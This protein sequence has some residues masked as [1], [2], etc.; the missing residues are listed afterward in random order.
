M[1]ATLLDKLLITH[2]AQ[3]ATIHAIT[4]A[5]LPASHPMKGKAY[6]YI[7]TNGFVRVNYENHAR[8]MTGNPSFNAGLPVWGTHV[9]VDKPTALISHIVDGQTRYYIDFIERQRLEERYID[10]KGKPIDLDP[11]DII[12]GKPTPAAVRRFMLNNI[13]EVHIGGE[14]WKP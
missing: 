11:N 9:H 6:K 8:K 13:L 12:R 7:R 14:I 2:H 4:E 5:K 1:R 10:I 3:P